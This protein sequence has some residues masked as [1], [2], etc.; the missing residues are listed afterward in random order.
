VPPATI[1]AVTFE[2]LNKLRSNASLIADKL[3]RFGTSQDLEPIIARLNETP[4][5]QYARFKYINSSGELLSVLNDPRFLARVGTGEPY[6]IFRGQRACDRPLR[7]SLERALQGSILNY[8][9]LEDWAVKQFRRRAH[10]YGQM[11]ADPNDSIEW[12]AL[13]QHHGAPTRFQDWTYSPF[14]AAFFAADSTDPPGSFTLFALNTKPLMVFNDILLKNA[15]V[16]TPP[17]SLGDL[18]FSR[19]DNFDYLRC[20]PR[21]QL[22][23][24]RVA[25]VLPLHINPRMAIQQGVFLCPFSLKYPFEWNLKFALDVLSFLPEPLLEEYEVTHTARAELLRSLDRMNINRASLFPGLDG[26]SRSLTTAIQVLG[27]NH[28]LSGRAQ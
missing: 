6:W 24:P 13:M 17:E 21:Y 9:A 2:E 8:G 18:V 27:Q 7:P 4:L 20:F 23:I 12:L 10:H 16:P 14:V 1:G 22:E 19:C 25:P 11:P 5:A 26:F 28:L 15:G 3:S